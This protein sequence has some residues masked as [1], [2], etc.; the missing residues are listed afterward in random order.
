[1]DL[2]RHRPTACSCNILNM[3]SNS[4]QTVCKE[5]ESRVDCDVLYLCRISVNFKLISS[6]IYLY[7]KEKHCKKLHFMYII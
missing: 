3:T 4:P 5:F 6:H 2:I 7:I 1:M